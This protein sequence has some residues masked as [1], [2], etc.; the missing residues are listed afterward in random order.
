MR[1]SHWASDSKIIGNRGTNYKILERVRD[2]GQ[3]IIH[4]RDMVIGNSEISIYESTPKTLLCMKMSE[5]FKIEE[6]G[7]GAISRLGSECPGDIQLIEPRMGSWSRFI[8]PFFNDREVRAIWDDKNS[9]WW[10]SVLD[11]VAVLTDQDDY[12][13]TRNYWKYLKAKLKKENSQVVSATTQL[14]ILTPDGKSR[15]KAYALLDSSVFD[16]NEFGRTKGLRKI[17]TCTFEAAKED[18]AFAKQNPHLFEIILPPLNH[19]TSPPF[20]IRKTDR[21]RSRGFFPE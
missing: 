20:A 15:T 9:N 16:N 6:E 13:K 21:R 4:Q 2:Q 17:K 5:K 3:F 11:I 12:T 8:H 18:S 19:A 7:E 10:F 14:K 1:R